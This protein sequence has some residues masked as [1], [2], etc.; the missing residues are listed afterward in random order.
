MEYLV[1]TAQMRVCDRNTSEYYGISGA[2]L[3]ERAAI[4]VA[5]TVND[6]YGPCAKRILIVCGA[7]NNGADGYAAARLLSQQGYEVSAL[8]CGSDEKRS[9]LNRMQYQT[10]F[11]YGV[12]CFTLLTREHKLYKTPA[13][14]EGADEYHIMSASEKNMPAY[15]ASDE[16]VHESQIHDI[17]SAGDY[18][19]IVDALFGIGLLREIAGD[20]EDLIRELDA[21]GKPVV[22]V[23]MPSGISSQDG[24]VMG[25]ALHAHAT[26]TFGFRK[27]G[28]A[29]YPGAAYAGEVYVKEIG[30]TKDSFLGHFPARTILHDCDVRALLPRR[31]PDGNKGTFGKIVLFAGSPSMSGACTLSAKGAYRAGAGMVRVITCGENREILQSTVPEALLT[32]LDA[33]MQKEQKRRLIEEAVSWADVVAAGPGIGQSDGTRETFELLYE[34]MCRQEL[35]KPLILDADALNLL[36]GTGAAEAY[37]QKRRPYTTVLTPHVGELA[38]LCGRKT[39]EIKRDFVHQAELFAAKTGCILAAKDARTYVCAGTAQDTGEKSGADAGRKETGMRGCL[40][41][42]GN[43][44]MATA[45]SG[46]VLTGMIAALAAVMPD[47][48]DAACVGV[49]LHGKA[50]DAAAKLLGRDAVMATDLTERLWGIMKAL[51][52]EQGEDV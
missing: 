47:L 10:A 22:A 41:M 49:Y 45:G 33:D 3:M 39:D 21:W 46:D 17:M 43:D 29:L 11:R 20:A 42:T 30:I 35:L 19:L 48:Y 12:R 31:A 52:A 8:F 37:L 4:A 32:V 16:L 44:G 26:V 5:D 50:G 36:A 1:T 13:R 7:G 25:C 15:S 34:R 27:L 18:D 24:A 6:L 9:G 28:L 23:D 51:R 40:N 38:R 14:K 2:V